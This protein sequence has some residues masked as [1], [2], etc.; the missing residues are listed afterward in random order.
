M[1]YNPVILNSFSKAQIPLLRQIFLVSALPQ[2]I[3]EE[4]HSLKEKM[5]YEDSTENSNF[6]FPRGSAQ[7]E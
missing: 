1:L 6:L 2:S 4:A 7:L 3:A 5:M